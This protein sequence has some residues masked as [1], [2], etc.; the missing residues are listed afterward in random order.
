[1]TFLSDSSELVHPSSWVRISLFTLRL[2][3]CSPSL[4][5]DVH[6][7]SI[8]SMKMVLG[9]FCLAISKRHR[10]IFSDSPRYLLA[11]VEDETLKNVVPHSV[12]TALASIVFPVPGGPNIRTPFHGR[13]I[14][15]K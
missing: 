11:R 9:A 5:L 15:L 1:M 2:D 7:E 14:P 4:P 12:A 3:S 10:T 8:S 13:L 6:S